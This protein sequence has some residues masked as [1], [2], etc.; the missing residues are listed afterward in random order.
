MKKYI[1]NMT[2][3]CQRYRMSEPYLD[4][5]RA[6]PGTQGLA[7]H[8]DGFNFKQALEQLDRILKRESEA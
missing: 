2:A 8:I 5:S 1:I 3:Y 7:F 6:I 4:D